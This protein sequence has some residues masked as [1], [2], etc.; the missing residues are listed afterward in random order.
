[1]CRCG[2][3]SVGERRTRRRARGRRDDDAAGARPAPPQVVVGDREGHRTR[4]DGID[5]AVL[6]LRRAGEGQRARPARARRRGS[7]D[8]ERS[9]RRRASRR[10]RPRSGRARR[11]SRAPGRRASSKRSSR[12]DSRSTGTSGT[13]S[14]W[15]TSP[16]SSR[17]STTP[18]RRMTVLPLLTTT[19]V[20][21]RRVGLVEVDELRSGALGAR[22]GHVDRESDAGG[23]HD[24]DAAAFGRRRDD[25][26]E[27]HGVVGAFGVRRD[28]DLEAELAASRR[29]GGERVGVELEP[30]RGAVRGPAWRQESHVAGNV[31]RP[32][33]RSPPRP[34]ARSRAGH[35][36]D[37]GRGVAARAADEIEARRRDADVGGESGRSAARRIV[38][39]RSSARAAC[40]ASSVR[41]PALTGS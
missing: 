4:G 30:R 40:M 38:R 18:P 3:G 24:A 6:C 16:A 29:V 26:E 20:S 22:D 11:R 23:G 21:V 17:S 13:G 19:A 36:G 35:D 10:G 25:G 37:R 9:A 39:V 14:R 8:L 7:W 41:S 34:A 12:S 2:W 32:V 5:A 28:G 27:D 1:M 31:H 33:A 15:T